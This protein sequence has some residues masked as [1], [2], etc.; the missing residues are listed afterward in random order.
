MSRVTP[1]NLITEMAGLGDSIAAFMVEP[2]LTRLEPQSVSGD[3]RH[4]ADAVVADPLWMI[5]RQWQLGELLGED[6][7]TP[8][9]VTVEHRELP[10][11]AWAPGVRADGT[12]RDVTAAQADWRPWPS[13]A[14]LDELVEH[15]V[16]P[17]GSTGLRWRARAGTVLVEMLVEAGAADAAELVV[18][19]CP[20]QLDTDE[21][22]PEG[23]F[24]PDAELLMVALGDGVADGVTAFEQLSSGTP[25]WVSTA[26]D[27]TGVAEVTAQWAAW[28]TGAAGAGGCWTTG[29]LE[30]RF[31]LRF[32]HGAD[33]VVVRA[34]AFGTGAARW[35]HFEW[36]RT[37]SV[38]L[39]GDDALVAPERVTDVMLA[40]PLRYPG[41]PADRYWQLEDGAVDVGALEAQPHDLARLCLAEFAMVSGDDWLVVPVD[42]RL[43][44]LNQVLSVTITDT[45]GDTVIVDEGR[46]ERIGRGFRMFEVTNASGNETAHGVLLPPISATPLV[47]EPLE[48]VAFVRDETAN[49]AWAVE[50]IV[51]GRSGTPRPR[52]AEQADAG[53]PDAD[54]GGSGSG[55]SESGGS[56][57]G[58]SGDVDP[59]DLVYEFQAPV[60]RHWIPLVPT[61][62]A[63]ATVALRKGAMVDPDGEPVHAVSQLLAPTPL[64]FPDEE[65]PREGITV[66]TVPVVA[67]RPDGSYARWVGHR[68]SVGRG[69]GNSGFGNDSA[70]PVGTAGRD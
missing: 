44:A 19:A 48:E 13:G 58:D 59:N 17:A 67:R 5:G 40:T 30:H 10:V 49:M 39:P 25:G 33:A 14:I 52:A 26:N 27:P 21:H 64:T 29:R 54:S 1:V 46:A 69:E 23:R 45:F 37:A 6:A 16:R 35:H 31:F 28:M 51:T 36:I 38:T 70:R 47:G 8:V 63:P 7:G 9:S 61:R 11:T 53:G 57:S 68:I 22:D 34:S 56:G 15:V 65:I 42:G 55:G 3:P 43:G 41:M 50:R 24:D 4:G 2:T 18:E 62:V 32:G 66:R 12:D 60:P 20:L